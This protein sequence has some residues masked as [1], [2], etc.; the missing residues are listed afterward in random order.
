MN[1]VAKTFRHYPLKTKAFYYRVLWP[2]WLN[3]E[4]YKK[5]LVSH[6]LC[7]NES[8]PTDIDELNWK[9]FLAKIPHIKQE[10]GV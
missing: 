9:I 7:D 3:L 4:A 6:R 5:G 1:P 8:K 10:L 2:L